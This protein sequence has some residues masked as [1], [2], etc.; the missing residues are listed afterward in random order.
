VDLLADVTGSK[1]GE[2]SRARWK[3]KDNFALIGC[4]ESDF[5]EWSSRLDD[6]GCGVT[7]GMSCWI[8]HGHPA[9]DAAT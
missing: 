7:D 2:N 5:R 3:G 9:F 1:D 4:S 8:Q 6:G